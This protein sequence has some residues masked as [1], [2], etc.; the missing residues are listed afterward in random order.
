MNGTLQIDYGLWAAGWSIFG[1]IC[2]LLLMNWHFAK[3]KQQSFLVFCLALMLFLAAS[4]VPIFGGLDL[5]RKSN[6]GIDIMTFRS[7]C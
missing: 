2:G 1:T 5:S 6:N 4:G 3:F 7:I